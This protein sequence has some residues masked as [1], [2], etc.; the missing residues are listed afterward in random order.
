MQDVERPCLSVS[1]V[2]YDRCG[3][4]SRP[5]DPVLAEAIR[6]LAAL[7]SCETIV[8]LDNS[9]LSSFAWTADLTDKVLYL[10]FSGS[11][12]GYGRAH[13][14]AR[15]LC[16]S[17]FHLF[18]NPDIVFFQGATLSRLLALMAESPGLALIQPLIMNPC[19]TV[20]Q[21]LCKRNPTLLAQVGRGV[22]PGLYQSLLG[23]Y[24]DWYEMSDVAYSSRP[25]DSSY[26][27]GC[28][29]LCRRSSLDQV[30]WFDPRFFMYLE[31]ADLTR[32]L[33]SIGRCVH[34]PSIR[35]GHLWG[36]GSHRSLRLKWV[37]VASYFRYA[38][39]WGYQLV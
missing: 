32:R 20:V 37:A 8:V 26:L 31:D 12:L 23:R 33:S 21:R 27:S 39:K 11:N 2:V 38:S 10:H 24:N 28:F 22:C 14:V 7:P 5:Q 18:L 35:V 3:D 30:G 6:H 17:R 25:V 4:H 29:M 15:F 34:E 36:R 16:S 1:I 19:G 13:N 9:L